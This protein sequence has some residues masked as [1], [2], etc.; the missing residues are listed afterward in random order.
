MS[1]HPRLLREFK[2]TK[3]LA[4][5]LEALRTAL[6]GVNVAALVDQEPH[7]LYCNIDQVLANCKRL[8]PGSD[9]VKLLVAQPQVRGCVDRM[10]VRQ[11]CHDAV[12]VSSRPYHRG[13]NGDF[14]PCISWLQRKVTG[15]QRNVTG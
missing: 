4:T 2:E 13:K 7:L 6:P 15:I 9:P 10:V 1:K 5:R 3:A 8:M 11:G 14:P 12:H